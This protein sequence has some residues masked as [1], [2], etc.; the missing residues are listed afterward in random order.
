MIN[1]ESLKAIENARIND[2]I[3]KP[4][5]DSYC[6]SQIPQMIYHLLTGQGNMGLPRS[7]LGELPDR[8][9]KVI[10]IFVDAFGWRFFQDYVEQSEFLK[11]FVVEGVASKL[12]TQ[13]PSTTAAH[14]TTI[15]SG[16]PVGE[17][18]VF[19]WFYYEPLLDDIIA[20]LMFSFAGDKQRGTL[21]T[22]GISE[23]SLF[24]TQTLYQK[25]QQYGVKSYCFQH[26]NYAYSPFSQAV[27]DGATTIPYKTIPEALVN[28][29]EAAVAES[30]KSYFFLYLDIVDGIA[31]KYGPDS[32]QFQAEVSTLLL[33]MER[34]L[35]QNVA[36][37][38]KNTL[39]L[40]TADHGQIEISPETTIYLNKLTP[41]IEQFIKR[42]AQGKLLVPAGSCRDM[43]LYIQED[44]LD[45]VYD[46][47]TEQLADRATVCRT[48][49][50]LEQGYFGT[51]E[52]SPLLLNRLGNLVILP[53]KYE[54]VWWYEE[55]RF[56][57]HKLGAHGGLSKEEMETILLAIDC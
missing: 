29:T 31:H 7:V 36:G 1:S 42:N 26:Y 45:K 14:V 12:T 17:S 47:L 57:Q 10:L 24:P 28:L 55:E 9:D 49:T 15:H 51:G 41:S 53:H 2:H 40:I 43:V 37:K 4:L 8:Y 56:E 34:L 46:L 35:Y 21:Q 6:F 27:C 22:T 16:L 13:F 3:G 44:H 50:L 48:T 52:L 25:L 11:R 39:L 54:T 5:Y 32:L 20:P 18:G 33:T 23:Q 30:Q 19:H 38:L